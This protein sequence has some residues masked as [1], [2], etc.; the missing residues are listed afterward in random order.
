M[1][2][3]WQP[4]KK[5]FFIK[6][7]EGTRY[8]AIFHKLFCYL[9]GNYLHENSENQQQIYIQSAYLWGIL[10]FGCFF[11]KI[12]KNSSRKFTL[13]LVFIILKFKVWNTPFP[14]M[15]EIVKGRHFQHWW[16]I[17]MVKISEFLAEYRTIHIISSF[18]FYFI[19]NIFIQGKTIQTE[20]FY[21]GALY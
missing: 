8:F 6:I 4:H 16:K 11:L 1:L 13:L 17:W 2:L 19:A 12:Q 21:H 7:Y 10:V 5:R 20:L 3:P 15:I 9:F 18:I 14:Q